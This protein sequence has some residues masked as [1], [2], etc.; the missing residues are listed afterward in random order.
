M[1]PFPRVE[2]ELWHKALKTIGKPAC[3]GL[4]TV[5]ELRYD[6]VWCAAAVNIRSM[7]ACLPG[8]AADAPDERACEGLRLAI[9]A[10]K[11]SRD[12]EEKEPKFQAHL[13]NG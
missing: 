11:V 10:W 13:L 6:L 5:E 8:R 4:N 9:D 1:A 12:A 3:R 7:F 2:E